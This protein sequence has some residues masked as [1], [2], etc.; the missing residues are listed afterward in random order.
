[1]A[2]ESPD[3]LRGKVAGLELINGVLLNLLV[4][5]STSS[6]SGETDLRIRFAAQITST[7]AEMLRN[8]A[9]PNDLFRQG[10]GDA[11]SEF[12]SKLLS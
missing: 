4:E 9:L 5:V 8:V 6:L 2:E 1:M 12:S 3:Y 10:L 11:M 7:S